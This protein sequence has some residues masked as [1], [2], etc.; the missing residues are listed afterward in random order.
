M[1]EIKACRINFLSNFSEYT[2]C[3]VGIYG[4]IVLE[5]VIFMFLRKN[6][7][8]KT[9]RTHLSIVQGYRDKDGKTRHKTVQK[10]GY[11]DELEKEYDDPIA[12]FTAVAA[13]MNEERISS[14]IINVTVDTEK[15]LDRNTANRKN[16]G[17]I[18]FSKIYHELEID[19][20]LKNAR[21]HENFKF[22][23]DAIMRLLV[24]T[25]L[26]YPGSKRA[27]HLK[28]E[29]FFD[30]FKFS[31]DDIY[32]AL[33][34]FDKISISLQQHLH[35]KVKKEYKRDTN[36]VY[37]DVTNYYFEIDKQD[38]LRKKGLSKEH[39]KDPIVQMGLLLDNKSL[40][41]FYKIFPGNTHDSQTLMP[42]IAEIKKKFKVKR[43]ITVADKALN[44]GDNI[45]F[46]TILG[47][48][49][50]YSKSIR[51]ASEDFKA[52]VLNEK[53]YR[54]ISDKYKVKSKIVP[55]A[56]INVTVE[57]RG[58]KKKKK[59][60]TVE[61]KW[62]VYY[63]KKYAERAKHKR[64]EAIAKAIKMIENPAL[65]KRSFDYGAAGYIEN[66][67]IDKETG[68]ISNI[69]DTLKLDVE[70][71][72]EEQKYDGY[73]AIVTSELDDTDEH[74]IEMYRGLWRIE[75]SF[76]VT[77]SVLGVRPIHLRT[78]EH[79]NAHFLIC[80]VSLLIARI[81][82]LKLKGKYTIAK[83]AETLRNVECSNL[84]QNLWLFDYAD[85]VTDYINAVFGTDIGR[86]IMTL[87]EIKKNLAN[88]KIV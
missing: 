10:V 79:I 7:S 62:V 52:W 58:K 48:G 11:V 44:S 84:D 42:V 78:D 86:Q 23:N 51:G 63:S 75:E 39:R 77:K 25:R 22:N 76:K 66:L 20:F 82:E 30:S 60:E 54:Q 38:D 16:Y 71:I 74:I 27:S 72:E 41:I 21:R 4:I 18:V 69:E 43:I 70:R 35:E 9:G 68:E 6:Y 17:Y 13:A 85:D 5:R 8:K 53:G 34:H 80:F 24:Y 28:K 64:E 47:N 40:P 57:Q 29:R 73:Y 3:I 81:I 67:K 49:Y 33:T 87:K 61:Q 37:Y 14:K 56:V 50:I 36:L 19:R 46:N 15:Q 1:N 2:L 55:D 59:K 65:Y 31:L 45:A 32:N 88:T 83:I 26:L 12:H